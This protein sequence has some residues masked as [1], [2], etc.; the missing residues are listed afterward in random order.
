[1]SHLLVLGMTNN[2]DGSIPQRAL[3]SEQITIDRILHLLSFRMDSR[4][5]L[6]SVFSLKVLHVLR[7]VKLAGLRSSNFLGSAS[8]V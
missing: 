2:A 1:M 4:T 6:M 8:V 5:Y 3:C 7:E